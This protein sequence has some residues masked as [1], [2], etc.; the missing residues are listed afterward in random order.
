MAQ[1]IL[2]KENVMFTTIGA[3]IYSFKTYRTGILTL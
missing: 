2:G 3:T 1:K